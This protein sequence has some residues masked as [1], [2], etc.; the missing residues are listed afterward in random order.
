MRVKETILT[1]LSVA[2]ILT[3]CVNN[4]NISKTEL[5]NKNESLSEIFSKMF[6]KNENYP[7]IYQIYLSKRGEYINDSN[8]LDNLN[9]LCK[10]RGGKVM[11]IND[12]VTKYKLDKNSIADRC[13][14][15]L[16]I[17]KVCFIPKKPIPKILF[18]WEDGAKVNKHYYFNYVQ[19]GQV[20]GTKFAYISNTPTSV[21]VT[22]TAEA[23]IKVCLPDQQNWSYFFQSARKAYL[24]KEKIAKKEKIKEEQKKDDDGFR[25]F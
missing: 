16:D 6:Y 13:F 7:Y 3:G 5:L 14:T 15:N 20:G 17:D 10:N 2:F 12:F 24:A 18:V 9:L 19:T 4:K 25:R 23:H 21:V 22:H 11:Y 1:I 8:I